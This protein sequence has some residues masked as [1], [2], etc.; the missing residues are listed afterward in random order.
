VTARPRICLAC[1]QA[2][3]PGVA[4]D[5]AGHE[6]VALDA[7]GRAR[8][9]E[10]VWGDRAQQ[11]AM[12]RARSRRSQRAATAGVS[13]GVAAGIGIAVLIGPYRPL[14][15]A[16]GVLA[17]AIAGGLAS[18]VSRRDGDM[19]VPYAAAALP[20]PPPF[21]RG[22][23]IDAGDDVRS[24]ASG[25]W[26]A[27]WALE[28]TLSRPDGPRVVLR[29]AATAALSIQL[30]GG[31]RAR[32]PA[33]PWRP[34]GGLVPLL[35]TDEPTVL[36]HVRTIDPQHRD[37]DMLAPFQHDAVHEA[38]LMVGDRVELHGT[39]EPIPDDRRAS[40]PLYRDAPPSVLIPTG[41]PSLRRT[42]A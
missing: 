34:A 27:G 8:L 39:W 37:D 22:V 40:D 28:L 9:I 32:V 33:G 12:M 36:A 4:C 42:R 5:L 24:P 1:R 6:A 21:A 19:R 35:D 41:W 26:C 11:L 7:D 3:A 14:I 38:L 2:L 16:G 30:D 31:A 25:L 20:E 29:D 23:I 15:L 13:T 17:G 18:T 10:A